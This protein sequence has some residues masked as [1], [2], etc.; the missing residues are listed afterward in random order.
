MV[1][2]DV[3]QLSKKY[4]GNDFYSLKEASFTIEQGEIV[5]LV[6]K[7][8]SGKSTLLKCLAKSQF[9]SQGQVFL[10]GQDLYAKE[11]LLDDCGIMIEPVFF[12]HIS[13]W[14][15]TLLYLKIHQKEQYHSNIQPI[16]ELVGLWEARYRKPKDFSFGMKQRTA[17]ALAL[18]TEPK[19]L[20]LDEPFVGLDPIG[21]SHLLGILKQWAETKQTAMLVSSHQLSELE[22]LCHRFLF[23]EKGEIS[24]ADP[25]D[26]ESILI[27]LETPIEETA[28][29]HQLSS[30]T[31]VNIN[32]KL[33]ELPA[34]LS[35]LERNQIFYELAKAQQIKTVYS[36]KDQLETLFVED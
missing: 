16:L 26:Q 5:G 12:P 3:K 21:V 32:S 22:E 19:F 20:L 13:V 28:L 18:L 15:N 10:H 25:L 6:G 23:I 29:I 35:Q 4:A 2:L 31:G 1:L 24:E 34:T 11:G 7:N 14:D 9:P 8:G 27:E 33:V 36:K 17:L 30:F